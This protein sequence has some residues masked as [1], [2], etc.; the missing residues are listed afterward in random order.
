MLQEPITKGGR[1]RTQ[2]PV[3]AKEASSQQNNTSTLRIIDH[4]LLT[5][6]EYN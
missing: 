2:K 4:A 5:D 3:R 6:A 1:R